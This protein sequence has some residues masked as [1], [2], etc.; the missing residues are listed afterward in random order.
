M[1]K[2]NRA[3]NQTQKLFFKGYILDA[4]FL[5]GKNDVSLIK[6]KLQEWVGRAPGRLGQPSPEKLRGSDGLF[7]PQ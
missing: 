2:K 5:G 6:Q 3:P 4:L 1:T 7:F